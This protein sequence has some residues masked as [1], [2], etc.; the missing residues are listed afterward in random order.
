MRALG[1]DDAMMRPALFCFAFAFVFIACSSGGTT[2]SS[3]CKTA[4]Q[5]LC[6]K[7]A[8]CAGDGKARILSAGKDG[9]AGGT[10]ISFT[11]EGGCNALYSL[12]C[13]NPPDTGVKDHTACIAALDTA[14]CG[15]STSGDKGVISPTECK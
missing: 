10:T 2:G 15:T 1:Y 9:G 4:G 8:A 3:G 14:M 6:A 12:A 7:A 11:N 5:K 13:D